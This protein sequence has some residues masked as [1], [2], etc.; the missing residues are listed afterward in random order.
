MRWTVVALD[1]GRMRDLH[2]I[3]VALSRWRSGRRLLSTARS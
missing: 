3:R 2:D 1:E